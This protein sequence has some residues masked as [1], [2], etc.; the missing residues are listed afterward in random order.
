M[1]TK[2]KNTTVYE[3]SDYR[4]IFD[5]AENESR[6][7]V[8]IKSY[9][10]IYD[11]PVIDEA[12]IEKEEFCASKFTFYVLKDDLVS[13]NQ[14]DAVSV[15]FDSAGIFYGYVFSKARDKENL[16]K[17]V[18]Y[19]QMRYLKNRRT[20]TR[21]S[22]CLEEIVRRI[23]NDNALRIGETDQAAGLLPPV[24]AD[25]LSLLD[26]IKKACKEQRRLNGERYILYDDFGYLNLKNEKNL[27][28][29]VMIDATGAENYVYTDTIDKDVYNTV[30]LYS[31]TKK[32]NLRSLTT[33]TDKETANMWGTLILSKKASDPLRAY[34][35]ARELLA[36]YN[37][38]NRTIT[39]KCVKGDL[40][41]VPGCSVYVKLSMGDLYFDNFVRVRKAVHRFKN[42]MY[43]ADLYLD[44]SE[45][46]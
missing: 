42:N 31:D 36:E 35:E 41:F 46:E 19:D 7:K 38:I 34:E 16:I 30:Q 17:V 3:K 5:V 13:F 27:E 12:V 2:I 14:G 15:K 39:L 43:S 40:R 29:N 4:E 33:I 45:I 18:C 23:G 1:E 21:G 20:Y 25:N 37:K 26:V 8:Y 28:T 32:A 44:G 6:L 24:A 22:M 9:L 11:V 10:N